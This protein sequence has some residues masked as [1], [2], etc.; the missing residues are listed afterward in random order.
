MDKEKQRLRLENKLLKKECHKL[1]VEKRKLE[2]KIGS[3]NKRLINLIRYA[4]WL[5]E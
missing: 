2:R 4:Q 5:A 3:F 1:G